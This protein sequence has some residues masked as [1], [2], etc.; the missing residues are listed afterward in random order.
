MFSNNV[1]ACELFRMMILRILMIEQT[2]YTTIHT[3]IL[4]FVAVW[5]IKAP[6]HGWWTV[7]E[8][9]LNSFE[10]RDI[11]IHTANKP[12]WHVRAHVYFFSIGSTL[13]LASSLAEAAVL[14]CS[15]RGDKPMS[16]VS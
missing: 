4:S 14:S 2:L 13:L 3:Y 1:I 7:A 5:R 6:N 9:F 15:I 8:S 16:V 11:D 12:S 10:H